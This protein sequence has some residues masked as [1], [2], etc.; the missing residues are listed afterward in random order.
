MLW[1]TNGRSGND[2]NINANRGARVSPLRD[3][4][5]ISATTVSFDSC[6]QVQKAFHALD[7]NRKGL[8]HRLEIKRLC[9]LCYIP[10]H[11]VELHCKDLH[12]CHSQAN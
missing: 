10:V 2:G 4:D 6:V 12:L 9:S 1:N 7:E 5:K 3:Q 8:L 11:E